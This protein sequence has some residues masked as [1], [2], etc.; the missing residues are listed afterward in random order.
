[1]FAHG[2]VVYKNS[3]IIDELKLEAEAIISK[4]PPG[5]K[6][7]EIELEKYFIDDHFKDHEDAVINKDLIGSLLIRNKIIDRCIAILFKVQQVRRS[8]DKRLSDKI[9]LLDPRFRKRVEM[10][11]KENW[12]EIRYLND[13]RNGIDE[14]LGGKRSRV[15]KLRSKLDL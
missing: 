9:E 12:N 2:E 5:L 14:L 10:A 6:K 8:K 11:L 7:F 15:W 1:M 3:E 13:L 4:E